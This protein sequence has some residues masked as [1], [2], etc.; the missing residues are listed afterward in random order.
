VLSALG[1][2]KGFMRQQPH[3][4]VETLFMDMKKLQRRADGADG[5]PP[6]G[7]SLQ[8][9][10]GVCICALP[11]LCPPT[12]PRCPAQ[13]NG[14]AN[15]LL[16]DSIHARRAY[17]SQSPKCSNYPTKVPD[18]RRTETLVNKSILFFNLARLI[19]SEIDLRPL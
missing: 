5:G 4:A 13:T 9:P 17:R 3:K 10:A 15:Q 14:E 2:E 19:G 12:D 11:S 1:S 16:A 8:Q 6:M 7:D 18:K